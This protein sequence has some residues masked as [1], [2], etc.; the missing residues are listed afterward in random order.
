MRSHRQVYKF[1]VVNTMKRVV[2]I[3]SH[4]EIPQ[5][6]IRHRKLWNFHRGRT[7]DRRRKP[8]IIISYGPCMVT[9][10]Y[11]PLRT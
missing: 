3:S 11:M 8:G 7:L 6:L 2:V 4:A 5:K 1:A 9:Q 10:R